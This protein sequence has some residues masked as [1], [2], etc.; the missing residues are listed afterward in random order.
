MKPEERVLDLVENANI[1][2]DEGERLLR[3][4]GAPPRRL[5]FR[6]LL[7]PVPH[8]PGTAR[9]ALGVAGAAM[10]I[11]L[12][13]GHITFRGALDVHL[14]TAAWHSRRD[15]CMEQA[16]VWLVG[17]SVLWLA[18]RPFARGVRWIDLFLG[19]G[20]ARLPLVLLGLG[21]AAWPPDVGRLGTDRAYGAA[22]AA[23]SLAFVAWHIAWLFS[24]FRWATGLSSLR[25]ALSFITGLIVA[26][27]TIVVLFETFFPL[28][29]G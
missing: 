15:A 5:T 18:G 9:L 1:G 26:E 27:V 17:A 19:L 24:A 28:L 25:L 6:M 16:I 11:A 20:V 21:L 13:A 2:P 3:A 23:A 22:V 14:T 12:L 7:N 10:A 8:L 4:L 29:N